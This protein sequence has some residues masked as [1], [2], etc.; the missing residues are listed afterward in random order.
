MGIPKFARWLVTR[1][2]LI[3]KKINTDLDVPEIGK[4]Y[5]IY[6]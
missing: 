1:Y 6:K 4:F 5:Y 3:L 2:P